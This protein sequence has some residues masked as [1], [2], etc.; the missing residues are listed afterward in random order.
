MA[1]VAVMHGV[2]LGTTGCSVP[3]GSKEPQAARKKARIHITKSEVR[4]LFN[5]SPPP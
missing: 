4:I 1:G 3:I 5:D 2:G